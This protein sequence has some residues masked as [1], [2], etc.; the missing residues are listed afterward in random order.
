MIEI[1]FELLVLRTNHEK[2][3]SRLVVLLKAFR[4]VTPNAFSFSCYEQIYIN[5]QAD[6]IIQF[7][8]YTI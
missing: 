6:I 4:N 7:C 5:F 1:S 8:F 2:H 3:L